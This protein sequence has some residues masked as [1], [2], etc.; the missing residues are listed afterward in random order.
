MKLKNKLKNGR[1]IIKGKG[2]KEMEDMKVLLIDVNCKSGSTGKIVYDL[3]GGL[4]SDGYKSSICYGRGKKIKEDNVFKFGIDI[5]TNLHALLTRITGF[6][7][8]FSFFSTRRLLKFMEKYKPDVVHL[9]ELHGYF[10]NIKPIVNYLKKKNI[11]TIWTFHC[12]FMYTGRCGYTYGCENWLNGCGLCPKIDEYPKTILFDFSRYMYLQKRKIMMD[13]NNLTIVTPSEWLRERVG[14]SFLN[15]KKNKVVHNGIDVQ[16]IFHRQNFDKL[17]NKHGINDEKVILAVAPGL[18]QE[19]KGGEWILKLAQ[20]MNTKKIKFILI[21]VDDT[22]QDFGSNIIALGRTENQIEL[23]QYYSMA[24]LFLI[25]SVMEN[26][27]TVCLEAICCGT[28]ICGFDVGGTSETAPPEFS[29][30]VK[31]S[32]LSSLECAIEEILSRDIN[33]KE[34]EAYGIKN[35]SKQVMYQEYKELYLNN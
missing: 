21:G 23:A 8:C 2:I 10:V 33:P 29:S 26:F 25:C 34:C 27:P 13:F 5:E 15:G 31:F 1:D 9:H 7:G 14:R 28:P 11:K 17:K 6:T 32:D 12:E 30:F 20:R 16:N 18:M 24:D 3:H 35:Y 19:R 22:K 4:L